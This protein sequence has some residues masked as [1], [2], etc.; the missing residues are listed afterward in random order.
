MIV[1]E[2]KSPYK[3]IDTD[4][5]NKLLS[6]SGATYTYDIDTLEDCTALV[7]LSHRAFSYSPAK[8][9]CITA[10]VINNNY[11]LVDGPFGFLNFVSVD[12]K[13]DAS[14]GYKISPF[15]LGITVK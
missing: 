10:N 8:K 7:S 1:G 2:A 15:G 6:Y 12:L 14:L 13:P 5:D 11:A 9:V 4:S 3:F